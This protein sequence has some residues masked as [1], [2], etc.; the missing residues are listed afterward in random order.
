MGALPVIIT[1]A[2]VN[3]TIAEDMVGREFN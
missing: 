1:V 3:K 2:D